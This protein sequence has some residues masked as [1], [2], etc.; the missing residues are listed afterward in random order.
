MTDR[1]DFLK[2][3]GIIGITSLSSS[4]HAQPPNA[5]VAAVSSISAP[6]IDADAIVLEN[7]EVR[8]VIGADATARSLLHKPTGQEC[9]ASGAVVPMFNVT[10]YRPYDNE[11]Q[12]A[13]PAKITQ[14]PADRVRR[15]GDKLL[16]T[17]TT[18]GYDGV[19]GL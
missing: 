18:V 3:A 11:L 4:L 13:Y 10:N 1:R 19:I 16:V 9:L 5:A 2:G 8:L 14:F 6:Q 12:L 7:A 17:F 15:E